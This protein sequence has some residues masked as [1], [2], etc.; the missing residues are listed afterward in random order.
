MV[1]SREFIMIERLEEIELLILEAKGDEL[2]VL[3][4]ERKRLIREINSTN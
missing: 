2:E 3:I 1:D 4:K